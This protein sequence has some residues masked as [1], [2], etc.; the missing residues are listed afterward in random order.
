MANK[1]EPDA[2]DVMSAAELRPILALAKRGNP[3]ACAIGLTKTK[4]GVI[5]VDKRLKPK[6]VRD[7]LKKQAADVGLQLDNTSVRFGRALVDADSGSG[8]TLIISVNKEAP[9]A[10]RLNLKNHVKKDGFMGLEIMT[11]DELES[12]SEEDDKHDDAAQDGPKATGADADPKAMPATDVD[13]FFD[14]GSSALTDS[15][16]QS[17]DKYAD[18]YVK[19]GSTSQV[20]VDGYSSLDGQADQNQTLSDA[21][22]QTVGKYL[23]SKGIPSDRVKA[24]GHGATEQ[25]EHGKMRPNRRA[26]LDPKPADPPAAAAPAD[27]PKVDVLDPK[28][29]Q[30]AIRDTV[31]ASQEAEDWIRDYLKG[32]SLGPDI[33]GD[34]SGDTVMF[35]NKT[36]KLPV[37]ISTTLAAGRLAKL[38]HGGNNLITA[39][40]V[41]QIITDMLLDAVPKA[42][43]APSGSSGLGKAER[44]SMYLQYTFT[45]TTVHTPMGGGP[46]TSDQPAHTITGQLTM[47]FHADNASGLEISAL[48]QATFFADE[49]G[50]HITNQ[51][52]FTG[53]QVAWVWSF[54]DGALQAG[55]QFQALIGVS[56]TQDKVSGK[57]EWTPTGQVGLGGQVQYAIPGLKGHV[58]VGVQAGVSATDPK[59]GDSTADRSVAFTFTYKF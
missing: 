31:V 7:L 51:S 45:P 41:A 4:E 55:P 20:T 2:D 26:T 48:G 5:L 38:D 36:T 25:F 1:K 43:G 19:A 28:K 37:V 10:L 22:A 33:A 42:P 34:G 49:K 15:D 46:E 44:V 11:D 21:R 18:A 16:K 52:G 13:I 54:L 3:V 17:L 29:T 35:D 24:K 47:E 14:L 59:G 58:L 56:K 50:G 40:R 27:A 57:L 39:Q 12:E 23:I 32:N 9:P 8:S 6:K 53:A 30:D